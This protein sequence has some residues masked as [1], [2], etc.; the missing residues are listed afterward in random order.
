MSRDSLIQL[1]VAG[2]LLAAGGLLLPAFAT[3][4]ASLSGLA[5]YGPGIALSAA[6]LIAL[7]FRR[8]RASYALL[9]LG[10]AYFALAAAGGPHAFPGRAVIGAACVLVPLNLALLALLAER[11]TFTVHGAQRAGVIALETALVAW[12]VFARKTETVDWLYQPVFGAATPF[13][14]A[15]PQSG[16][17]AITIA[18][19]VALVMW[20]RSRSGVELALAATIVAFGIAMHSTGQ[21]G[22]GALMISTAAVILAIGVL[23][24][25]FRMAYRDELT[26]LP[27]RRAL[28]ERLAGLGRRYT[29]AM[30]DVDHFKK[31]NDT[32]G[33]D[34]G[35]QVLKMVAVHLDAVRGGG[36][37]YRYGGEEFTIVFAGK[38]VEDAL[39]HL[40]AVRK[41]VADYTM[42]LRG[43]DRPEAERSGRKRRG[44]GGSAT[45]S[46]TISIGVA[47]PDAKNPEADDVLKAADRALYRAKRGGRNRV[48]R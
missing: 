14:T 13:A 15:I 46:V 7:A 33:H 25:A 42:A 47:E 27:G 40:E 45:V 4:P 44:S 28:N 5:Q 37:A 9:T 21:P 48:S 22:G 26:G 16:L 19:G 2:A 31:F 29:I 3:L 10:I 17:L 20:W 43:E 12:V 30:L 1:G 32:H 6:L 36:T 35:D 8:G 38:R 11:G 41:S 24:D 23:Q 39:P 34:I 18:T